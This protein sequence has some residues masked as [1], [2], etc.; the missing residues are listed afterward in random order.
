[1]SGIGVTTAL[2]YSR[3]QTV[4]SAANDFASVIQVAKSRSFSQ[5]K[6]DI[7]A[8][9]PLYEYQIS[10]IDSTHYALLVRCGTQTHELT[11][12]TLPTG[13]TISPTTGLL[14][15]PVLKSIVVGGIDVVS[16]K[17]FTI[18]GYSITR[19]V[20]IYEDARIKVQ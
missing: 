6:P 2:N 12:K 9:A 20:T 14:T 7:C 16:G 1:M 10:V 5:S 18:A 3:T 19:T 15:F 13:V 11:R 4:D 8:S 17:T